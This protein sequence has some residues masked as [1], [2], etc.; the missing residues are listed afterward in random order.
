M[1]PFGCMSSAQQ[2]TMQNFL[3]LGL[4]AVE[5]MGVPG[6]GHRRR[7]GGSSPQISPPRF[8]VA[9]RCQRRRRSQTDATDAF[10]R[11]S[12]VW[13][14]MCAPASA[15]D[16]ERG[17]HAA[18]PYARR[19]ARKFPTISSIRPLK[20][21]KARAPLNPRYSIKSPREQPCRWSCRSR[22]AHGR[23]SGWRR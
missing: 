10:E 20:R 21:A 5:K 2:K 1:Q 18:S 6:H 14:K 8:S 11:A 22:R 16:L 15:N 12:P 19:H 23:V 9:A 3:V 4:R 13:K 17:V 7:L